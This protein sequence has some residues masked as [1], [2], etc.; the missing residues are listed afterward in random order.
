MFGTAPLGAI[1]T[2]VKSRRT[3]LVGEDGAPGQI[4]KEETEPKRGLSTQSAKNYFSNF[5]QD[6]IHSAFNRFSF[7]MMAGFIEDCGE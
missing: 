4:C 2:I 5:N 7:W 3:R 6:F 1:W